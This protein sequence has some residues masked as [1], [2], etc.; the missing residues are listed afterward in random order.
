MKSPGPRV[1]YSINPL[2]MCHMCHFSCFFSKGVKPIVCFLFQI[3]LRVKESEVQSLKQEITSLKDELQ[4]AQKVKVKQTA[5]VNEVKS[6][7]G[8]E[9]SDLMSVVWKADQVVIRCRS[10]FYTSVNIV[11]YHQLVFIDAAEGVL[12]PSKKIRLLFCFFFYQH[13]YNSKVLE[14]QNLYK[15]FQYNTLILEFLCR[16]KKKGKIL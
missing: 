10:S 2:K 15:H 7:R 14:K 3:T 11:L 12:Q 9:W 13:F 6:Q 1:L 8:S 4:S 16:T 5:A